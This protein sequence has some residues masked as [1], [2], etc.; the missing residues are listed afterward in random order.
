M[1]KQAKAL[2]QQLANTP[3]FAQTTSK[4]RKAIARAGKVLTWKEGEMGVKE[5]SKAAA[6]YMILEGST[7]VEKDGAVVNRLRVGDFFGEVALLSGGA[8]TANVTAAEDCT[9]FALGR[10]AFKAVVEAD[11]PL[12]LALLKAMS[13]RLAAQS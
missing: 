2:E 5:G 11:P 7:I 3:L 1:S 9:L 10:P 13:Q 8:R 12:S 4:Q 6:F